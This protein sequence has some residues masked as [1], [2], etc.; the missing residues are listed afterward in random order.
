MSGLLA[1]YLPTVLVYFGVNIMACWSL[2]IQYGLTG[3][4]NFGFILSQAMGAYTVAVL[5]VGPES[6]LGGFQH[7]IIGLRLPFPIPIL[8]GGAAGGCLAACV[9]YLVMRNLTRDVEAVI[10][11]VVSVAAW[12][13][14]TNATSLFN[15]PAGIA[16]IPQPL[17]GTLNFTSSGYNWFYVALIAVAC[18]LVYFGLVRPVTGSPIA[19]VLR[20]VRDN[21]VAMATLGRDIRR[22]RLFSFVIGGVIAGIS[23]AMLAGFITTWSPG[24]W[25]YVETFVI[26]AALVVGGRGNDAGAIM[27][28]A[29]V[30]VLFEEVTRFIPIGE[31]AILGANLQW[32]V[33]GLLTLIFLWFRPQGVLPER[34]RRLTRLV[35]REVGGVQHER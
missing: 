11:L 8:I 25:V 12:L 5:S 24:S 2:N 14:V 15:G 29:L 31:F 18:A 9:G 33:I 28:A 3:I 6:Q 1:L 23:G 30:P 26:F 20:G 34:R 27:G 17:A 10:L 13:I 19:R 35:A 4:Y 22:Y 32:V 16:N 7:Y 21:P